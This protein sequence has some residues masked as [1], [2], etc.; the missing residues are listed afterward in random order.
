MTKLPVMSFINDRI[1]RLTDASYV[2]FEQLA[3]LGFLFF[4][5]LLWVVSS[6]VSYALAA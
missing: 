1:V 5:K 4:N 3:L 2:T 6:D